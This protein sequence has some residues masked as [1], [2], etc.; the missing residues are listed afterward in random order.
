MKDG[1]SM[2]FQC[3]LR[4]GTSPD[5]FV[6][7]RYSYVSFQVR[8]YLDERNEVAT[9]T[10]SSRDSDYGGET[11]QNIYSALSGVPSSE[12]AEQ[13]NKLFNK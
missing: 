1:S 13:I 2:A 4:D 6:R 8:K 9:F 11:A 7:R 12:T 3:W 5:S 10:A